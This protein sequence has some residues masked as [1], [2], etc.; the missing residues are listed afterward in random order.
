MTKETIAI[1]NGLCN[2]G[3]EYTSRNLTAPDCPWHAFAVSESMDEY[4]KQQAISFFKWNAQKV[5]KYMDYL[6]RVDKAGGLEEMEL[7]LNHFEN[8]T[9]ESRYSQFIEQQNK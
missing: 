8:G 7:A 9:I 4:A 2:C 5:S 3:P 1:K 6:R